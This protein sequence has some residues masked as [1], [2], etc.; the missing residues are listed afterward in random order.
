[1]TE[2]LLCK[3]LQHVAENNKAFTSYS[4]KG[5]EQIGRGKFRLHIPYGVVLF[6]VQFENSIST[7]LVFTWKRLSWESSCCLSKRSSEKA[8]ISNIS[9]QNNLKQKSKQSHLFWIFFSF[10][11]CST[12]KIQLFSHRD[13]NNKSSNKI[14][15]GDD[16]APQQGL[17]RKSQSCLKGV[18][19]EDQLLEIFWPNQS[20]SGYIF[21]SWTLFKVIFTVRP[22]THWNNLPRVVSLE[23]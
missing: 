13:V 11:W 9:K 17:W 6:L 16:E 5:R 7:T 3:N 12:P 18:L 20:Q 2:Q 21:L 1:M 10:S 8:A 22:I 4:L 14:R 15:L 23:V 19:W